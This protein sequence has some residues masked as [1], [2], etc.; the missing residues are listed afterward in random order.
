[1][2]SATGRAANGP[3]EL[4]WERL[5]PGTGEPLRL[6]MGSA[7]QRQFWPDELCAQLHDAGFDVV[8]C[9]AIVADIAKVAGL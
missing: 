4:A 8:P 6:I 7:V 1:M 3:V 5:G 2:R 9:P